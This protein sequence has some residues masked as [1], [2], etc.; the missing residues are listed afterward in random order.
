[1]LLVVVGPVV[2]NRSVLV[3]T[4]RSVYKPE[5]CGAVFKRRAINL[6]DGCVRLLDLVECM[7]IHGLTNPKLRKEVFFVPTDVLRVPEL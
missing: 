4:H 7:M 1:V 2:G 3:G 6:R 5:T